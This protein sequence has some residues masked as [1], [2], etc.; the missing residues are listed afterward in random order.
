RTHEVIPESTVLQIAEL[1]CRISSQRGAPQDVEWAISRGELYVLQARPITALPIRP[2]LH[3]PA[4]GSWTKDMAHSPELLTPFGADVYLPLINHATRCAAEELGVL[5]KGLE[6]ISLGGEVYLRTESLVETEG[7]NPPWW[8]LA[9]A[10]RVVPVL[11]S[12]CSAAAQVVGSGKLEL[13]AK[14]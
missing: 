5:I 6:Y 10:C 1:V 3:I 12:R 8:M 9:I 7:R 2:E 14:Q 4:E 11:R 13:L